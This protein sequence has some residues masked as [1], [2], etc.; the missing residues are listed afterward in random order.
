MHKGPRVPGLVIGPYAKRGY[1][2]HQTLSFD[3]Y[4]KLIEDDFLDDQR[5]DHQL[6][7]SPL[8]LPA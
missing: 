4:N 7:G 8:I 2:D 3:A 5:L 6:P 1:I